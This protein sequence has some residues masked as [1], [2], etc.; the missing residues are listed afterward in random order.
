MR[1]AGNVLEAF[2]GLVQG[3]GNTIKAFFT[4]VIAGIID[5]FNTATRYLE[6]AINLTIKGI[7]LSR[8]RISI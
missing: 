7:V 3:F 6:G 2:V 5:A 1:I 4:V 8:N